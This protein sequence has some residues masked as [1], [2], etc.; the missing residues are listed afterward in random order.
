MI[1]KTKMRAMR[2]LKRTNRK[3]KGEE[4]IT[5]AASVRRVQRLFMNF[6]I[7]KYVARIGFILIPY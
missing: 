2:T 3:R 7:G 5:S 4:N 1:Q 6:V